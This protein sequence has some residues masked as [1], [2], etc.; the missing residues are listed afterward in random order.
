[1]ENSEVIKTTIRLDP[2]VHRTVKAACALSGESLSEFIARVGQSELE[3]LIVQ[4]QTP[5]P[6]EQRQ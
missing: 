1:M 4:R 5:Q 3:R 6:T 2:V